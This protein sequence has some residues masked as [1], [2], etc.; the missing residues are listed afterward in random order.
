[1]ISRDWNIIVKIASIAAPVA[2]RVLSISL[3][4]A[5]FLVISSV[6]LCNAA[7]ANE[8]LDRLQEIFSNN[9]VDCHQGDEG[10]GR[11]SLTDLISV[12]QIVSDRP[13]WEQIRQRVAETQ[14]PPREAD[15]LSHE[16][17]Q[18]VSGWISEVLLQSAIESGPRPG[19]FRLR[20]LN[21]TQYTNTMRDLLGINF[22]CGADLPED[23]AGGEGF[24]NAAETLFLSPLHVER[25]IAAAKSA[26]RYAATDNTCRQLLI[27]QHPDEQHDEEQAARQT[28]D[29]FCSRAFRHPLQASDIEKVLPLFRSARNRQLTYEAALFETMTAVVCSPRFLMLIESPALASTQRN[30]A[31]TFPALVDGY[32]LATRLSYFL[33]NSMPDEALRDVAN[34]L[35]DAEN[36]TEQVE[37]M[38]ADKRFQ[39][40]CESFV[41]QWLGTKDI[42]SK[43]R[44]SSDVFPQMNDEVADALR[45][46]PVRTLEYIV[47]ENRPLLDLIDCNYLYMNEDIAPIYNIET[48]G[49]FVNENIQRYDLPPGSVRGGLLTMAG[50]LLVSSHSSRTSPVLRGKWLLETI[51]GYVPPPPPPGTPQLPEVGESAANKTVRQ[52]LEEHRNNASCASC[53]DA[54]DPLGFGLECFDPIGKFRELDQGKPLDLSG[55]L[56]SGESFD[57]PQ[58]LKELLLRNKAN[59]ARQFVKR[60]YGFAMGRALVDSDFYEIER[61]TAA[62]IDANYTAKT[63]FIEIVHSQTFQARGISNQI[64]PARE[65]FTALTEK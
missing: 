41:G 30:Q 3:T 37:R 52:R 44:P 27:S 36:L 21:Q 12:K 62:V 18:F 28:L 2:T 4:N 15:P 59:F 23:G 34:Q 53:H 10:D 57:G 63:A 19:P 51:L 14:M 60:L 8:Q 13:K 64:I 48:P 17:R 32:E 11:I 16:D 45:I 47:R 25:Y 29:Q 61:I 24:D 50:P 38:I 46:E 49:R 55:K 20:R 54:I 40:F 7:T 26:F 31:P 58:Q 35:H 42:G 9:C 56:P 39:G 65:H 22:D 6:L 5:T 1:M 33:Y 43:K